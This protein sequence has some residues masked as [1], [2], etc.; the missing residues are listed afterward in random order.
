MS[1]PYGWTERDLRAVEVL[2]GYFR[3][4][5]R[6]I[7]AIWNSESGLQPRLGPVSGYYG[8]IM[9]APQF[10][11]SSIGQSLANLVKH[12]SIVDQIAAIKTFWEKSAKNYLGG[13]TVQAR[14]R[15]LGVRG[16]TVLYSLNFVPAYFAK[17][18]SAKQ[19]MIVSS[20]YGRSHGI[21]SPDGGRFYND[22][23]GFDLDHKGYINVLDVQKRIDRMMIQGMA[24]SSPT[25]ALFGAVS[26]SSGFF[27][28]IF[29]QVTPGRAGAG[30]A[31]VLGAWL[32]ISGWKDK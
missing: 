25:R 17:M 15:K 14:A 4:N 23:P 5:P 8:L 3:A 26:G 1:L 27:S 24:A 2:A 16:D 31:I 21:A 22:T 32:G 30:G 6:G 9:A 19:P 10:I 18:Q 12:G 28:G 13:D 20:A 29:A 7:L 11:D